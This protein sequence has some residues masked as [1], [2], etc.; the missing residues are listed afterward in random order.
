MAPA[1]ELP[2]GLMLAYAGGNLLSALAPSYGLLLAARFL[3]GLPHRAYFGVA[4]LVAADLAGRKR[5]ARAVARVLLG[6]SIASVVG[7]P[8]ATAIGQS[9]GWRAAFAAAALLALGTAA[10]GAG[11]RSLAPGRL[12][13]HG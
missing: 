9:L 8:A 4:S 11:L 7:V 12:H 10:L 1:P 5:R 13:G 6:L 3:A 2:V